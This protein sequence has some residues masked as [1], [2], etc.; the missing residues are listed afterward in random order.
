MEGVPSKSDGNDTIR[1]TGRISLGVC[2]AHGCPPVCRFVGSYTQL[3]F[4][5][6]S[7]FSLDQQLKPPRKS[8]KSPRTTM[9]LML[10][11]KRSPCSFGLMRHQT[12]KQ[13]SVIASTRL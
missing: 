5:P 1:P 10:F 2:P 11:L 9:S 8:V 12:S 3:G 13:F 6:I 7:P 4:L